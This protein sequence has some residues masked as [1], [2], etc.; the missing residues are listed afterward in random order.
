VGRRKLHIYV[1]HPV[2]VPELVEV[3]APPLL[4]TQSPTEVEINDY[5]LRESLVSDFV[6]KLTEA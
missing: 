5:E 2:D 3:V 1:E 4:L 6:D